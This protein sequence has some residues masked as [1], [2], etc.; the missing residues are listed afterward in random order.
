MVNDFQHNLVKTIKSQDSVLSV[1]AIVKLSS[2]NKICSLGAK[3][4]FRDDTHCPLA[5]TLLI[6]MS[7]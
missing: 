6:F 5:Q 2:T 3:K 1:P 4:N 7:L